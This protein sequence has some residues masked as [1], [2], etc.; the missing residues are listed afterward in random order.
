M[1]EAFSLNTAPYG[2]ISQPGP[3]R[4]L[5]LAQ[6]PNVAWALCSLYALSALAW[7]IFN[8]NWYCDLSRATYGSSSH[9]RVG[10][11]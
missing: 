7:D 2:E 3:A 6:A 4:E 1:R 9:V 5:I 8:V 10:Q 11:V